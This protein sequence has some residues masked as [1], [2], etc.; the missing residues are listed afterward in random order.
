MNFL[1]EIKVYDTNDERTALIAQASK[2]RKALN[3]DDLRTELEFLLRAAFP[4]TG[5]STRE[6]VIHIT[7][8]ACEHQSV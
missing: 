6:F 5:H 1:V 8:D 2:V 3:A 7:E 4:D